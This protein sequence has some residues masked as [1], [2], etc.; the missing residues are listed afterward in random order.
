MI[1]EGRSGSDNVFMLR[2]GSSPHEVAPQS[3]YSVN[4]DV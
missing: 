2:D 4:L 1:S 3:L